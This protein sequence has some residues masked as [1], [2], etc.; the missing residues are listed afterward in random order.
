MIIHT[1]ET[2]KVMSVN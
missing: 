1:K 2:V